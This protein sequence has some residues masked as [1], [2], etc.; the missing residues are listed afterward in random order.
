MPSYQAALKA[1]KKALDERNYDEAISQANT[2]LASEKR[3]LNA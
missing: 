1:A 2:I 3:N